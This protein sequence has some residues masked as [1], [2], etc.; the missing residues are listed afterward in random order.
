MG[1]ALGVEA[2]I[3]WV[4]AG[5]RPQPDIALAIL[6]W[7]T[8]AKWPEPALQRIN[9]AARHNWVTNLNWPPLPL[10]GRK[11]P[12]QPFLGGLSISGPGKL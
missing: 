1:A 6:A 10:R 4:T 8:R 7:V 3:N 12:G 11:M 5:G 9:A 2:L